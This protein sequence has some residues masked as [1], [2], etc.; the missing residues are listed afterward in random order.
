MGLSSLAAYGCIVLLVVLAVPIYECF[1]ANW[2]STSWALLAGFG[3]AIILYVAFYSLKSIMSLDTLRA[4]EAADLIYQKN[5]G[6]T[7]DLPNHLRGVFWM[8]TNSAPE[9]LMTFEGTN[10]VKSHLCKK[11]AYINLDVGQKFGW[12]FSASISWAWYWFFLRVAWMFCA[13]LH[14]EFQD[15]EFKHAMLPMYLCG[16]CHDTSPCDGIEIPACCTTMWWELHQLD[17]NTWD[18]PIYL[19]CRPWHVCRPIS[20]TLVRVI[21]ENG[22]H[23]PAFDDMVR[24]VEEGHPVGE[25]PKS[26]PWLSF[27]KPVNQWV[28]GEDWNGNA[29][30]GC[31]CFS[32]APR[33][34]EPLASNGQSLA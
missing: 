12:S 4:D 19:C 1:D 11:N 13:E 30:T 9:L 22:Q 34:Y 23:L 25:L 5:S 3:A 20:Y 16:C 28:N 21:D 8:S 2:H 10:F 31:C 17:E 15:D 32:F 7:P 14:V 26:Y 6:K 29:C 33:Q 18:R 27:A 24:S